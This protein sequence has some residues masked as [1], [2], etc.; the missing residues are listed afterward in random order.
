MD[1]D[2]V[3]ALNVGAFKSTDGGKTFQPNAV[4]SHSD[5]HDLWINP[6]NNKA[7][8][9]G[10]DGGATVTTTGTTWT[11]QDTQPT[12]EI[13]RLEVD[14]RWPYWVYGAQQ[15]N[16]TIAVPSQ[17][18]DTPYQVGGGESGFIAVDPRDYNIVYAGNYGG[19]LS[20]LDRKINL[21]ES[22]RVYADMQTGQR[23]AD[24]K[25][26]FQWN[27]PILIS[28]HTPDVVYTTSQHVHRSTNKGQDWQTISPDLTRNEK[29]HQ[30]YS[31]GEGITRDSTGVEVY[32]TIFALQ[33]SLIA[34]GLLWAGSDDGLVHISRDNGKTW[35]NVTPKDWPEGCIN[36]IDPSVHD[37]GRAVVAMYRYRQGDMKPYLYET[38]D[39]GKTWKRIADGTNGIPATV[40]HARRA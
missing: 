18:S 33:E 11:G 4:Q 21:S 7:M 30:Q 15:D 31:G 35:V 17:G 23:A 40:L 34:P 36:S 37:P 16:S 5:N 22:I 3:Y 28:P 20:R 26:R 8:I 19:T 9:E 29:R 1:A 14:T 32:G 10:N 39:Y 38:N 12:A 13:Y 25:Y 24:M 6:K 2:T 27:T